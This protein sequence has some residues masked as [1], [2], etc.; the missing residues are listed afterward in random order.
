MAV[1]DL[2]SIVQDIR[3]SVGNETYARNQGGIYV[4]AR[5]GPAGP[6]SGEQDKSTAAMTAL[7]QWWSSDLTEQQ[8]KDWRKYAHQFPR[9]NRWGHLTITSGYCRFIATNFRGNR[10]GGA[11][12]WSD[13]P[14]IP[15]WH[16][17]ALSFT[18]D[19]GTGNVTVAVPPIGYEVSTHTLY[20][21]GYWGEEV[22]QGVNFYAS[23]WTYAG[24]TFYIPGPGWINDPWVLAYP[25]GLTQ[26]LR[27]YVKFII[28][29]IGEGAFSEYYQDYA[30]IT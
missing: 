2:G 25:G 22:G 6:P 14:L 13:A 11:I 7:S 21:E 29:D 28:Q 26:D 30:D 9:P 1:V 10:P 16:P 24:Q 12:N 23:P 17:P 5:A 8:R 4:R 20:M 18:A 15:P 19:S 3:G 27:L